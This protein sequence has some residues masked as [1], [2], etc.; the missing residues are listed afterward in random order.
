MKR[1]HTAHILHLKAFLCI[2]SWT[3][4]KR[5]LA[6]GAAARRLKGLMSR[7]HA[8]ISFREW[9]QPCY[10]LTTNEI[11]ISV[12]AYRS[13]TWQQ[14]AWI[15]ATVAHDGVVMCDDTKACSLATQ[16]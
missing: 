1:E 16:G 6:P 13:V 3:E 7:L 2:S 8:H 14:W 15:S 12:H 9:A 4:V 11:R 5:L 10:S